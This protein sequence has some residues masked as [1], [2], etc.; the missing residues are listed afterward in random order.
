MRYTTPSP[1]GKGVLKFVVGVILLGG[2]MGG[3]KY[4]NN[5]SG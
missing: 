2:H 4:V 3:P 1:P 5:L